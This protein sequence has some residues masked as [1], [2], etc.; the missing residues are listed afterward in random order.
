MDSQTVTDVREILSTFVN[1]TVHTTQGKKS[2]FNER[3]L[4]SLPANDRDLVLL[5]RSDTGSPPRL[6]ASTCSLDTPAATGPAANASYFSCRSGTGAFEYKP[7][8]AGV[9]VDGV[10]VV[11]GGDD[12]MVRQCNW[13]TPVATDIP[14]APSRTCA[15]HLPSGAGIGIIGNQVSCTRHH[16]VLSDVC[17]HIPSHGPTHA[18]STPI[19][20]AIIVRH[21]FWTRTQVNKRACSRRAWSA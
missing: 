13:S 15:G 10:G 3:S 19:Q 16:G 11:R 21:N 7:P 5:L 4:Y 20:P 8:S 6:W 12:G 9:G 18:Y 1:E 14:D 17:T 2:P